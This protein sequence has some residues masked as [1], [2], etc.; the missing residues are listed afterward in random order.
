MKIFSTLK[1]ITWPTST[2]VMQ[3]FG[4]VVLSLIVLIIFFSVIDAIIAMIINLIY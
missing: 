1:D 3:S 4:I 2:K